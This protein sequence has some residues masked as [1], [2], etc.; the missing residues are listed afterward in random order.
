MLSRASAIVNAKYKTHTT[1]VSVDPIYNDEQEL[2]GYMAYPK[3]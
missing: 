2:Q 1:I 3:P